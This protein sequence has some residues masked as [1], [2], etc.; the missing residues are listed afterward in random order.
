MKYITRKNITAFTGIFACVL[1]AIFDAELLVI[2]G[3]VWVATS[4]VLGEIEDL[5]GAV[6]E[7]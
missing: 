5:R 1:G 2:I 4:S 7:N 6:N 3:T